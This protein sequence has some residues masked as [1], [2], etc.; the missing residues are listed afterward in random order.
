MRR[1]AAASRTLVA[2]VAA[3][4]STRAA[5]ALD[6]QG[7]GAHGGSVAGADAGFDLTG[8]V[9]FGL[10]LYNPSYAARPD[11][12]GLTLA[13]YAAHADV[14]LIGRRLSIPLDVN[15]FTDRQREGFGMLAPTE[16]DLITGVTSTWG[17]GERAAFEGGVRVEHD[18]PV[19]R[20]GTSQTYADVRARLM[21]ELPG[22]RF[23]AAGHDSSGWVTLGW[24][25]YN[26]TQTGTY[27]A[28]PDN[29]GRALFRYALHG[30][31]EVVPDR[32]SLALDATLFSDSRAASPLRPS[33]LDLTP[34]VILSFGTTEVHLAYERDMPLD[35]GGLSQQFVYA[36]VQR[37][38]DLIDDPEPLTP[39]RRATPAS[40]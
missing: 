10:S 5:F 27:F 34:E 14:D 19:D 26:P 22:D 20:G 29:T 11:N 6:K 23:G 15:V 12:T 9:S 13:R 28:R 39:L 17:L 8:A 24:F 37:A 16:L 30:S 32:L 1:A 25:A 4:A 35:R 33:E 18:R 31:V 38:F 7:S 21:G 36:L 2:L 3:L 40:P